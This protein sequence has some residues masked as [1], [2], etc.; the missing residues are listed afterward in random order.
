MTPQNVSETSGTLLKCMPTARRRAKQLQQLAEQ[1]RNSA[2]AR[3][4]YLAYMRQQ[5]HLQWGLRGG[6]E[7]ATSRDGNRRRWCWRDYFAADHPPALNSRIG[8][9]SLLAQAPCLLLEYRL[10]TDV[11][12][13]DGVFLGLV[14]AVCRGRYDRRRS[15][16]AV[17]AGA[18]RSGRERQQRVGAEMALAAVGLFSRG[19]LHSG[20]QIL[21][22]GGLVELTFA[23]GSTVL[24]E[25]PCRFTAN[26][27]D[28]GTLDLGKL[29]ATADKGFT[30]DTRDASFVDL[31][32]RFGVAVDEAGTAEL[33]VFEGEVEVR[34]GPRP[35]DTVPRRV[36]AGQGLR[37]SDGG[38]KTSQSALKPAQFAFSIPARSGPGET[39]VSP[40]P[41][42]PQA[43]VLV[44]VPFCRS[45]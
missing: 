28:A 18:S 42:L 36:A 43:D 33:Y 40:K 19:Q 20:D 13:D 9:S 17:R 22:A 31:G 6:A 21:L 45:F 5:S 23:D 10:G 24:L 29:K 32:T 27:P 25:G 7:R 41:D 39:P 30:I 3:R 15:Q 2:S 8:R 38:K 14:G 26:A 11:V 35:S 44:A 37:V 12:A 1:L 16:G 4:L 34:L